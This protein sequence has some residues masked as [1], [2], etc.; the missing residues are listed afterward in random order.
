MLRYITGAALLMGSITTFSAP[1]AM[2]ADT[3]TYFACPTGYGLQVKNS[4]ARCYRP[5]SNKETSIGTC[6]GPQETKRDHFPDKADACVSGF[7]AISVPMVC[8]P[9]HTV[10]RKKGVDVCLVPVP[11]DVKAPTNRVVVR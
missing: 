2:A 11:E 5:A 8:A 10:V 4:A 3:T 6:S 9:G 1:A 7:G